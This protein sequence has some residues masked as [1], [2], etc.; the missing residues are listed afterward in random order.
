MTILPMI[1]RFELESVILRFMLLSV[2][3]GEPKMPMLK[4]IMPTQFIPHAF[5]LQDAMTELPLTRT[6][7]VA[8][9][10]TLAQYLPAQITMTQRTPKSVVTI[11]ISNNAATYRLRVNNR[12]KVALLDM[13]DA[14]S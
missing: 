1:C 6:Q 14:E 2:K 7:F 4:T 5:A 8:L 3:N 10:K 12:A 9:H 11:T 13:L